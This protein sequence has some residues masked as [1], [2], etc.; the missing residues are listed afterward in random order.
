M[1]KNKDD[2]ENPIGAAKAILM[3]IENLFVRIR[4]HNS[5][6]A[7]TCAKIHK[8]PINIKNKM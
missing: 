3:F 5:K 6:P 8:N 1:K 7:Q 4:E 2:D